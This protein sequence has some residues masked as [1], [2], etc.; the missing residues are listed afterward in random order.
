MQWLRDQQHQAA[1]ARTLKRNWFAGLWKGF[2]AGKDLTELLLD[3]WT[4]ELA[5]APT[6]AV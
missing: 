1:K 4:V 6:T 3:M 5:S 2:I